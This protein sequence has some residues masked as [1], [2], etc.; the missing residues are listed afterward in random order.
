[1]RRLE[2]AAEMAPSPEWLLCAFLRK[3]AVLSSQIE[4]TQ[5]TLIDLLR[6]EA[7][8]DA[9]V[10]SD[11]TDVSN[12]LSALRYARAELAKPRGLPLSI[13]LLNECHRR[14]MKGVRGKTKAPGELRRTQ[15]WVGGSRPSEAAYVPPP[16][17][18]LSALLTDLE[19]YIHADG[20]LPA[21][22][23][24]G[25]LHVQFE[26]IHPYLDGNG[27]VGRLL[28]S[29]LFEHWRL[30]PQPILYLS[31][32]FKQ[33]RPEYYRRLNAVR[34]AGD[35]EGWTSFFLEGVRDV[36]GESVSVARDLFALVARDRARVLA[37]N[38]TSVA[39][40]RL[41]EELPRHP[42]VTVASAIELLDTTKPTAGRAID[43]LVASG[44]LEETTGRR[45]GRSFSYRHYLDRL[46]GGTETADRA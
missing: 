38:S 25:L 20:S 35:W 5:A 14:L 18:H 8:D 19:A 29:L 4:G 22:V 23:R 21:L 3:E 32:H 12:Y 1:L 39:A 40:A 7:G 44:V 26:S 10:P 6:A 30:L 37:A 13:R 2:L 34:S 31:L 24:I 28:V 11:V 9:D 45:R 16:P 43:T 41:F 33:H 15:N 42:I 46:R 27:R 36:A 17:Q